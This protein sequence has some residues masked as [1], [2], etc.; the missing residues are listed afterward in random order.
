LRRI[1]LRDNWSL[2]LW[3]LIAWVAFLLFV[4][5]PWMVRQGR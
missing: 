4:V 5:V 2:E 3:L 1:R